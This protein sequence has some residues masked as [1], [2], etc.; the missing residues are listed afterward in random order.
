[1]GKT[2]KKFKGKKYKDKDSKNR[3]PSRR[4]LNHGGCAYCLDNRMHKHY[5]RLEEKE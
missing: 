1:M 5:K 2:N 4:C 3:K